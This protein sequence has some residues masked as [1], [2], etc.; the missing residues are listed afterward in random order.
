MI[1]AARRRAW[2]ERTSPAMDEVGPAGSAARGS[3]VGEHRRGLL[4][5]GRGSGAERGARFDVRLGDMVQIVHG[6]AEKG[7][8]NGRADPTVL[9][10]GSSRCQQPQRWAPALT[11]AGGIVLARIA[12][13]AD[14]LA[15]RP[16]AQRLSLDYLTLRERSLCGAPGRRPRVSRAVSAP[17]TGR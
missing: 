14:Q 8:E 12:V 11:L 17:R 5:Q 1:P 2:L 16:F 9:M 10:R 3:Q 4:G 7:G 6:R 13:P 15:R